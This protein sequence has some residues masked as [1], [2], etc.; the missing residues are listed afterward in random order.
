MKKKKRKTK[1]ERKGEQRVPQQYS[2]LMGE[3]VAK[4][5][6]ALGGDEKTLIEAVYGVLWR[7]SD[8][9]VEMRVDMQQ[10]MPGPYPSLAQLGLSGFRE[11]VLVD[12]A[13][14]TVKFTAQIKEEGGPDLSM[15]QVLAIGAY[16]SLPDGHPY[17]SQIENY[18]PSREVWAKWFKRLN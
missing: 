17:K 5:L 12:M 6:I 13:M 4:L 7:W 16:E 1:R 15:P 14:H 2:L 3:M 8:L 9:P 10:L 11:D 18:L